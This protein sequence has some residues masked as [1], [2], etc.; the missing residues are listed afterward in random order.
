MQCILSNKLL[1]KN[2]YLPKIAL[3][4]IFII[5][6][7]FNYS[8]NCF[9]QDQKPNT[10]IEYSVN[11]PLVKKSL[12]LGVACAG[13]TRLVAVGERGH[14]LFTDNGGIDW[15][16]A[17]VPT[18]STLTSVFFIDDKHGWA[19]GHDAIILVT[20]NGGESWAR[21]YFAPVKEQ[22]LMDVWFQDLKHGIAIGAYGI[23]LETVDGGKTWEE[24]YFEVLDNP[25][26]GLPHFNA[27]ELSP[28]KTLFMVGEAGFIAKSKD[29][30][31]SWE[32]LDKPYIGSYFDLLITRDG[33]LIAIGMRGNIY[34]SVDQGA[35]W[36]HI[37]TENSSATLNYGIQL[38]S[39]EIVLVGMEGIV[40]RSSDD[41]VSF[42]MS[43]RQDRMAITGVAEVVT[44]KLFIVG[45]D[46]IIRVN[47]HG[48]DYK[49]NN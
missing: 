44:R 18:I 1:L 37:E 21:Q 27:I 30:G 39:G 35:T 15:T 25:D 6:I 19:V 2:L 22:P 28:D 24:R 17:K 26:F 49:K 31:Q 12:L 42:K 23:Y 7:I 4:Y 36:K 10:D 40:L 5:F 41:G 11:E 16:Q 29:F 13:E 20:S 48:M 43:R 45:E 46:G 3:F 8:F 33:T 9:S 14:I 38:A 47:K 32:L 34:R